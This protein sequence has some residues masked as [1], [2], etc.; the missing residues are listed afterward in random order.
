MTLKTRIIVGL[1]FLCI[2]DAFIP[3]PIVGLIL[4]FGIL[5]RPPWFEEL[6]N[7]VLRG[8]NKGL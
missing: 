7:E 1:V 3:V 2:F 8:N 6:V 4:I 5:Q